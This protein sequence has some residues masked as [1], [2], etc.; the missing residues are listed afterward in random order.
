M[1]LAKLDTYVDDVDITIMDVMELY[2]LEKELFTTINGHVPDKFD[3]KLFDYS[4][5]YMMCGNA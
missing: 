2:R 5:E 1:K 4:M 3:I